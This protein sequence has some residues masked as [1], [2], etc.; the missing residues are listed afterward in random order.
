MDSIE[1]L[2][3][4]LQR[5]K[6]ARMQAETILEKKAL[7][8]YQTNQELITL[9]NGLEKTVE[10]RTT[11]LIDS[12]RQYR[13]LVENATDIIF[14]TD[15]EGYLT[16]INAPGIKQIGYSEEEIIGKR[17]IDFAP[18][19]KKKELFRWYRQ[20]KESNIVS[21]YHEFPI[22][23]KNGKRIWLGQN[24]N[25]ITRNNGTFYFS[26]VARNITTRKKTEVALE[27]AKE[28]LIRSEIK[29]RSI[30][31]NMKLGLLEVNLEH[32]I[33]KAYD[34]FAD[35]T[36]YTT[37]ELKG[38]N[39]METFILEG[40][41]TKV[42]VEKDEKREKGQSGVYEVQLK[43]KDGSLIWVLISGAPFYN[44]KGE[45]IGSIGIHYDITDRKNLELELE[46]AR[47]EA[48]KSQQAQ[49]LFL[50]NMN[51]EIRTPLNAI[52]GMSHLLME[53][54]LGFD[55]KEFVEVL[56]SSANIL[57]NLVSDILDFSKIDSDTIELNLKPF[58]LKKLATDLIHSFN[59]KN[60]AK[61]IKFNLAFDNK[62]DH[63][64]L[65]DAQFL[66]QIL[67]N[68]LNNAE[69]FTSQGVIKLQINLKEN[70]GR[71]YTILFEVIDMGIGI[72]PENIIKIFDKFRQASSET[73]T[74]YGGTGLGL[75]IAQRLVTLLGGELKV[76]S[77]MGVGSNFYFTI[78]CEIAVNT[79]DDTP[80]KTIEGLTAPF[81]TS[82]FKILAVEDTDM[83][84]KYISTLLKKWNIDFTIAKNG[85]KAIDIYEKDH[86]DLIFMDLQMPIMDGFTATGYIRSMSKE[87]NNVP[88]IA[89]T[90][91]TIISKKNEALKAGMT[92]FLPKPFTPEQLAQKISNQVEFQRQEKENMYEFN[93]SQELDQD[94]LMEAYGNDYEYA[95]EMFK[96]F[97]EIVRP[98]M[99]VLKTAVQNE[100][101]DQI[102]SQAHKLAPIFTMVG[103]SKITILLK[104]IE[105]AA[106][107]NE[108][109]TIQS[110]Y[111]ETSAIIKKGFPL[112]QSQFIELE[113]M[114]DQQIVE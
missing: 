24:V 106:I 10:D 55:Q 67:I 111:E 114:K 5:E 63:L 83:N 86:F 11:Q 103:L 12:E 26:A 37:A 39:A 73:R 40:T 76:T 92:D 104:Q 65:S 113:K 17:F 100:Q 69:K 93:Y 60:E 90:A 62:I 36:G 14:N 96:T 7:E 2:K 25:R 97:L 28:A 70:L 19:E 68:L 20:L 77:E 85:Q 87:K 89:M 8:L 74:K 94:Y 51:H 61:N 52:I 80:N 71:N 6:K 22:E 72:K 18:H 16:F 78:D 29:Y 66:N 32:T 35:M 9:N 3:R 48:I 110:L 109:K 42:M 13:I 45:I 43:K 49:K 91:S 38:K 112:V 30:I 102:K 56:F 34:S 84:I 95:Y 108:L 75:A 46:I 31:E 58:D 44:E 59:I 107:A 21:D 53:T 4:Q 57:K 15:E 88:I 50:A 99:K 64:I 79:S 81:K 47:Q 82:D 54:K 23:T 101:K 1:R 27:K 41:L 33:I 105:K 98:G